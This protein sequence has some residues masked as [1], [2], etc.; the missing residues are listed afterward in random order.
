VRG[1]STFQRGINSAHNGYIDVY[2]N[3]GWV[4]LSLIA[5]ILV[6]GYRR[7]VATFRRN[8]ELA[9]LMLAFV[10]TSA[11][12]SVTEA[13]FRILTPTW[14]CL[15]LAALAPSGGVT[16][17]ASR[18]SWRPAAV[19]SIAE[20]AP[21]SAMRFPRHSQTRFHR[22]FI[23]DPRKLQFNR[24]A[25]AFRSLLRMSNL[26]AGAVASFFL[27]LSSCIPGGPDLRVLVS[28]GRIH[29]YYSLLDLGSRAPSRSTV[30][31]D[32]A[33]DH[34]ECRVVF[35][36]AFGLQL[37]VGVAALLVTAW[38]PRP[39]ADLSQSG[40]CASLLESHSYPGVNTALGF[41]T[42]VYWAVLEAQL[43]F[44]VQSWLAN[45]G[46]PCAQA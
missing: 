6:G 15:L 40:G 3:L 4:G 18:K 29:R 1:L 13:G 31:C 35:N 30:H 33:Q 19:R 22:P 16:G 23:Y 44:D 7:T 37:L 36:T 24:T 46:W 10:A 38:W 21:R 41:P 12:Y 14:I 20:K 17:P 32:R 5:F 43:R 8:P 42:R 28:G 9:G 2:L 11:I 39:P 45:L 26:V 25:A 27:M 34:P